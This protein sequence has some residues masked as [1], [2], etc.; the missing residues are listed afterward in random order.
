[1]IIIVKIRRLQGSDEDIQIDDQC[2]ILELKQFLHYRLGIEP[3]QQ[4]LIFCGH[5]LDD[6]RTISDCNIG[7]NQVVHMVTRPPPMPE[8]SEPEPDLSESDNAPNQAPSGPSSLVFV[9]HEDQ[10]SMSPTAIR[11]RIL[12]TIVCE[13]RTRLLELDSGSDIEENPMPMADNPVDEFARLIA[14]VHSLDRIFESHRENYIGLINDFRDTN[15][16]RDERSIQARMRYSEQINGVFHNLAHAFHLLS[17]I[18]MLESPH[19][20]QLAS[21]AFLRQGQ[22]ATLDTHSGRTG[23]IDGN[24]TEPFNVEIDPIMIQLQIETSEPTM[25]QRNAA[26]PPPDVDMEDLNADELMAQDATYATSQE[27]LRSLEQRMLN[28]EQHVEQATREFENLYNFDADFPCIP[29]PSM[30]PSIRIRRDLGYPNNPDARHQHSGAMQ[31]GLRNNAA[32]LDFG[33]ELDDSPLGSGNL[34]DFLGHPPNLTG[35]V[36]NA[37]SPMIGSVPSDLIQ[38]I[39]SSVIRN[40]V[41]G[42]NWPNTDQNATEPGSRPENVQPPRRPAADSPDSPR[43]ISIS[44]IVYDQATPCESRHTRRALHLRSGIN[45][46][47]F[48]MQ[49]NDAASTRTFF[50]VQ[51]LYDRFDRNPRSSDNLVTAYFLLLREAVVPSSFRYLSTHEVLQV[52]DV[53]VTYFRGLLQS[54]PYEESVDRVTD[55]IMSKHT[56]FF[57]R[58]PLMVFVSSS[59]NMTASIRAVLCHHMPAIFNLI[60][61]RDPNEFC[62]SMRSL[63]PLFYQDLCIVLFYCVGECTVAL[64]TVFRAYLIDCMRTMD[65]TNRDLLLNIAFYCMSA[66]VYRASMSPDEPPHFIVHRERRERERDA[67]WYGSPQPSTSRATES[68]VNHTRDMYSGNLP[69]ARP[70]WTSRVQSM[71]IRSEMPELESESPEPPDTAA[72]VSNTTSASA[73][74]EPAS[75]SAPASDPSGPVATSEPASA[76]VSTSAPRSAPSPPVSTSALA[77]APSAPATAPSGPD[78]TSAPDSASSAPVSTSASEPEPTAGPSGLDSTCVPASAPSASASTSA[79]VARSESASTSSAPVSRS[80]S[81]SAPVSRSA[82]ASNSSAPVSRSSSV[83]APVSRSASTSVFRGAAPVLPMSLVQFVSRNMPDDTASFSLLNESNVDWWSVEEDRLL[84]MDDTRDSGRDSP[85]SDAY[86]VGHTQ[87]NQEPSLPSDINSFAE[88]VS[89]NLGEN[90]EVDDRLRSMFLA[91]L[92]TRIEERTLQSPDYDRT[93][94]LAVRLLTDNTISPQDRERFQ[95]ELRNRYHLVQSQEGKEKR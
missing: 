53:V 43:R 93:Q 4:R 9:T 70:M 12:N 68:N 61:I 13:L 6:T 24:I 10:G 94:F 36:Q 14:E 20:T 32:A 64:E 33:M 11:L 25:A 89:L 77:T 92:S 69:R 38:Q 78:S 67:T 15:G 54:V 58:I 2:T 57:R 55:I 5:V 74:L 42:A 44:N 31:P 27:Y 35:I 87:R 65:E 41:T 7:D 46:A 3:A 82:L 76:S 21:E 80:S 95:E 83:S 23:N 39:L 28:I 17:D 18:A 62:R 88:Y 60:S 75:T 90:I 52:G 56:Q 86:H 84:A 50:T 59:I 91:F 1:M 8:R 48:P 22:T 51:S 49:H 81:A 63:V 16:P 72:S 30:N 34:Q 40:E 73:P 45:P 71:R 85:L 66:G 26:N 19:G 47:E 79:S 37:Q 29:L